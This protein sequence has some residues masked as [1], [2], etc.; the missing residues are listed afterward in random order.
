[1][2]IAT[3]RKKLTIFFS[4]IKD[5]TATAERLQPEDLTALLNE[6][7]TDMSAI[8]VEHGGTVDKFIGDAMLVFFGDPET[9][10][11]QEDAKA[12]VRM[13]AGDAATA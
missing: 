11:W 2:T 5:F 3:E 7:L 13:A 1:M 9:A 12:C 8:A 10:A 4:D 6:Y